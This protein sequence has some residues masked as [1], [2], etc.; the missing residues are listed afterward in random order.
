V[1]EVH[2]PNLDEEENSQAS[3]VP[4]PPKRR[5]KGAK[6]L[7]EVLLI[8]TGVFLGLM[9]EQWREYSQ[10]KELAELSLSRLRA[11]IAVNRE[12]VAKVQDYHKSKLMELKRYLATDSQERG[13]GAVVLQ[14]IKVAFFEKTA[15]DMALATGALNYFKPDLSYELSRIYTL[16]QNVSDLTRGLT[17]AMYVRSPYENLDGFLSSVAVY[18]DDAIYMEPRLMEAYDRIL[19]QLDRALGHPEPAQS[20]KK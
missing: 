17:Q 7:L 8:S 1:P 11:E 9:G 2:L 18:Y 5:F 15:W 16:Q 10:H 13:K 19:P 20:A 14:G 4:V 6:L 12:A 3:A